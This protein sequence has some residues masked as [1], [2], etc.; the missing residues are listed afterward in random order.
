MDGVLVIKSAAKSFLKVWRIL[1]MYYRWVF[2]S[3]Y[4]NRETKYVFPLKQL[5]KK[6]MCLSK[7]EPKFNSENNDYQKHK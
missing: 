4:Y 7:L 1:K 3:F 2:V 6:F 5:E